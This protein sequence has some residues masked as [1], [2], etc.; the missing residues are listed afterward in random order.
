MEKSPLILCA[1]D[2]SNDFYFI[3]RAFWSVPVILERISDGEQ[4][5]DYLGGNEGFKDRIKHP[6]PKVVVI[7][8]NM[9]E[10]NGWDLIQWIRKQSQFANLPIIALTNSIMPADRES[11]LQLGANDFFLKDVLLERPSEFVSRVMGYL[12]RV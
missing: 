9:P 11:A 7:D 12:S 8:L 4:A 6:F 5:K 1:E 3:N 2:S 10:M